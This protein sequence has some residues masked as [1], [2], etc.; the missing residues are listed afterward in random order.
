M[1]ATDLLVAQ[2]VGFGIISLLMIIGA[3][4]V[5]TVN[6]VVHAALWR[7]IVL[8]GAAAQY[9]LLSAEFVAL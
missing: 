7:V 4:R 2:N 6:N 1:I 9:L 5:V 3:V 8:S